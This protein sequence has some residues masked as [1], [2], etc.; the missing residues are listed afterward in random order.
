[1]ANVTYGKSYL[2]QLL[3]MGIQ[4]YGNYFLVYVLLKGSVTYGKYQY[5][6]CLLWLE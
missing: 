6:K 2:C 1:M 5:G 4:N 3:L